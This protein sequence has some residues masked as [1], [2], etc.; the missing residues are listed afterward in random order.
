MLL[1]IYGK[2]KQFL[3][4]FISKS[5]EFVNMFCSNGKYSGEENVE[6]GFYRTICAMRISIDSIS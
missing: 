5:L 3:D 1:M 2:K 6:S 4:I